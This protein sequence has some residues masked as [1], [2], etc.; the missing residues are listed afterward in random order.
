MT[1]VRLRLLHLSDLHARAGREAEPWRRRRVLG[2][3]WEDNLDALT[4][5]GPID[6]VCFTGDAAD[7]GRREEF[8]EADAFLATLL[9]RLGL[10]RDRLFVVPGNH[11]IDRSIHPKAWEHLR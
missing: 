4:E 9:D 8:A 1:D 11:D 2:P 7:W 6:L 10:P 3:A 5:D